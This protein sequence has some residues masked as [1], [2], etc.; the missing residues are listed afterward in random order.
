LYITEEYW[1]DFRREQLYDAIRSYQ[2]RDRRFGRI[3][4]NGSEEDGN[5]QK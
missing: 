5:G 4:R 2:D 3:E 1:P